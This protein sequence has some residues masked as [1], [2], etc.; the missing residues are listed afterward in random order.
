MVRAILLQKISPNLSRK[1]EE[2]KR[3]SC[4]TSTSLCLIALKTYCNKIILENKKEKN[5]H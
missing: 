4:R 2:A 5:G 1:I 3:I